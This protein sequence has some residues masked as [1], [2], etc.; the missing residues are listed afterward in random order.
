MS[1][2]LTRAL[3]LLQQSRPEL[4]ERELRQALLA[5]PNDGQAHAILALCLAD[6]KKLE[7][8]TEEAK[9]AI[10]AGPDRSLGHYALA[11]VM[12]QRNRYDEASQ[13]IREAIRLDPGDADQW[14]ELA[15]IELE[16]RE[17]KGAL[18]AAE[19][20]LAID[21]EHAA[22]TNLRAIALVK[23]G[24]REE[25]GRTIDAALA[26][27]PDDPVTHANQGWT[28][29]NAG[30]PR[31]AMEHFRES[32]RLDP[33]SEWARAGI[34]EA[35]KARN[36]LY[37]W[38]L[39]YF[40]WASRLDRRVMWGLIVG[41][42]FGSRF[43]SRLGDQ[44]PAL[45]PFV[46]PII[47]A[48]AAFA[49]LTW[50]GSP[51]ANLL[52]RLDRFGRHALSREQVKSS[53]LVG[54][55]ILAAAGFL[56]AGL[57]TSGNLRSELLLDALLVGLLVIP[58][59]TIYNCPEGWPRLAAAGIAGT[60]TFWVGGSAAV[61]IAAM[62]DPG[63]MPAFL[64]PFAESIKHYPLAILGASLAGNALAGATVRR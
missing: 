49:L 3:L 10:V 56:V 36:P 34:V 33:T 32:L 63:S 62:A 39:A 20:G 16:R 61:T 25:A 40:L 30:E 57:L 45:R 11:T 60:L 13:A 41:F 44:M 7:P 19:R 51:L 64:A 38:L 43:L 4:A 28:L 15:Q 23:L 22:C 54:L 52:L 27:D 46:L 18:D 2:H 17:W 29:L 8:A 6:Q 31:K 1:P 35:M 14:G 42:W 47:V 5:D 24:R 59:S 12:R 21:P 26:R 53:N 58:I 55:V 50:V 48:Y 9:A 37:R